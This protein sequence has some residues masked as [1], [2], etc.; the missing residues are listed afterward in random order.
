M[1]KEITNEQCIKSI[2]DAYANLVL[3]KTPTLL[4]FVRNISKNEILR[5]KDVHETTVKIITSQILKLLVYL[6][7]NIFFSLN[8]KIN[9]L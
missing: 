5:F 9:V 1:T 6:A 2:C 4:L 8:L 7:L 3:G